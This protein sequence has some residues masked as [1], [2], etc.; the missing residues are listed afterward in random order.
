[1]DDLRLAAIQSAADLAKEIITLATGVLALTLT[2]AQQLAKA[3][4]RST[5]RFMAACWVLYFISIMCGVMCL[6]ALTGSLSSVPQVLTPRTPWAQF[7]S[8]VQVLSFAAATLLLIVVGS[9]VLAANAK[10][11]GDSAETSSQ[12]T[13][14]SDG[15][16]HARASRRAR[17]TGRG[18][19]NQE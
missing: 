18:S 9:R 11:G 2:F 6:M 7:P 17:R 10:L 12:H 4:S 1:M 5:L 15:Q 8:A 19:E 14:T 16:R 3:P 13:E